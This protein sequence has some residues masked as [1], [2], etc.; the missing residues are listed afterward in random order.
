MKNKAYVTHFIHTYTYIFKAI[1]NFIFPQMDIQYVNYE[2]LKNIR[3]L[4]NKH[5]R[6]FII[7]DGQVEDEKECLGIANNVEDVFLL[8]LGKT[9]KISNVLVKVTAE[10]FENCDLVL[11]KKRVSSCNFK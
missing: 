9:S 3:K 10:S 8:T 5:K 6:F 2:N 4:G 7:C 11:W 1:F